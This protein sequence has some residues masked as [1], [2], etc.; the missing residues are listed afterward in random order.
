MFVLVSVLVWNISLTKL[1]FGCYY[2][3]F[4]TKP[5]YPCSLG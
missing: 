2:W 4:G 3:Y 1:A 5:L